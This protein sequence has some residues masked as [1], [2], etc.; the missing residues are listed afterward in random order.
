MYINLYYTHFRV[1]SN[2][3]E[4]IFLKTRDIG[5]SAIACGPK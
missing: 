4:K 5:F 2:I 3:L 1:F